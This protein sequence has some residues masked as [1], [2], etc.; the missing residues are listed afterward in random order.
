[1]K[2]DMSD[3]VIQTSAANCLIIKNE[4]AG[5]VDSLPSA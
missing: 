3:K 4:P 2:P 5:F 1:M